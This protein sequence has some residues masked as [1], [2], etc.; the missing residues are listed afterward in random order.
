[1]S[2]R[3]KEDDQGR[4]S[5]ASRRGR[6]KVQEKE[7]DRKARRWLCEGKV[8]CVLNQE[9]HFWFTSI[10][11]W[12]TRLVLVPAP[13]RLSLR[14]SHVRR[15]FRKRTT[16][17]SKSSTLIG[18]LYAGWR[19]RCECSEECRTIALERSVSKKAVIWQ[20]T[21]NFF[22][23]VGYPCWFLLGLYCVAWPTQESVSSRIFVRKKGMSHDQPIQKG[24]NLPVVLLLLSSHKHLAFKKPL[25]SVPETWGRMYDVLALRN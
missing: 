4:W 7:R 18:L 20:A 12:E 9:F 1:M 8:P 6:E 23:Q 14:G 19:S 21:I 2:E 16:L 13:T 3:R 15:K 10:W 22:S 25:R 11:V 5:V 17:R 24:E